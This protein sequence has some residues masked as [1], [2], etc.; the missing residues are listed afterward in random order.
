M[1]TTLKGHEV[2]CDRAAITD[3]VTCNIER[4]SGESATMCLHDLRE[5]TIVLC[6]CFPCETSKM[7]FMLWQCHVSLTKTQHIKAYTGNNHQY[8]RPTFLSL[9]LSPSLSR[10]LARSLAMSG[11]LAVYL[12]DFV[13]LSV[14]VSVA[15]S[16]S[17]RVSIS[18][19][20]FVWLSLSVLAHISVALFCQRSSTIMKGDRLTMSISVTQTDPFH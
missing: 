13:Y 15:L 8:N 1:N 7:S 2:I 5:I 14:S 17:L 10:S 4:Q 19:W 20:L 18:G 6:N 9:S 16:L 12:F 3:I 11:C